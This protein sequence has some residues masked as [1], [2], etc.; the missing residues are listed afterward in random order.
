MGG[1]QGHGASLP[2]HAGDN[3]EMEERLIHMTEKKKMTPEVYEEKR[4][5]LIGLLKECSERLD[6]QAE[7]TK[8]AL[9]GVCEATGERLDA[10]ADDLRRNNF[11]IVLVGEF[12]GGKSTTFDAICDGRD[13]SPRGAG[14][15]TSAC[16]ISAQSVSET[17][18]ECAVLK[19]KSDDDLMRTMYELVRDFVGDNNDDCDEESVRLFPYDPPDRM[20]ELS[21]RRVRELATRAIRREWEIY[22]KVP[23]S[24]GGDEDG[25]LDLLKM[26]TLILK[27]H[28]TPELER[29]RKRERIGI[30]E[31]KPLVVFPQG[32]AERWQKDGENAEWTVTESAFAF[33]GSV[34]CH[35]HSPNLERLGC[36]VTDCPGLFAGPWDTK[37][38]EEAMERAD[39]ILY[40][41]RGNK[42][43]GDEDVRALRK[44]LQ[45]QQG[46]K[47][48]FAINANGRIVD[49]GDE[50]L[51]CVRQNVIENL[52]P[53]DLAVLQRIGVKSVK[54]ADDLDVF[55]A[56]LAFKS[57]EARGEGEEAFNRWRRDVEEALWNYLGLDFYDDEDEKRIQE[58]L[59]DCEELEKESG[60]LAI[61]RKIETEIVGRKFKRVLVD[62]GT[63]QMSYALK[64]VDGKL[65]QLEDAADG[66]I[67]KIKA[68]IEAARLKLKEF[69][70]F[71][72]DGMKKIL[73]EPNDAEF[74]CRDCYDSVFTDNVRS[75]E[76]EVSAAI[77]EAL[78]RNIANI[79]RLGWEKA[80]NSFGKWWNGVCN[81]FRS[82]E[83][84][85]VPDDTQFKAI[86]E[87][88]IRSAMCSVAADGMRGWAVRVS[89]GLDNRFSKT[90]GRSLKRLQEDIARR[91]ET[92]VDDVQPWCGVLA[93]M[94]MDVARIGAIQGASEIVSSG[95][96]ES[97][98]I[99]EVVRGFAFWSAI[100][101]V[102]SVVVYGPVLAIIGALKDLWDGSDD[103]PSIGLR[104]MIKLQAER[105]IT[106][107]LREPLTN[108]FCKRDN[109]EEVLVKI[110]EKVLRHILDRILE[111][112]RDALA[113]QRR[114][115]EE[116]VVRLL[117]AYELALGE[118]RRIAAIAREVRETV[119]APMQH[120]ADAF[121]EE[122]LPYFK[123]DEV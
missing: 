108:A 1:T 29:L 33:L 91:W 49:R 68:A 95:G 63:L 67:D 11:E 113:D 32:W 90:Y 109:R 102:L 75:Y 37:V 22:R 89:Q 48:F 10:I 100:G 73:N 39:A 99:K 55:N 81:F 43:I 69:Q 106:P 28:G 52:R 107:K 92:I 119:I 36:V 121:N 98:E 120:K 57:K 105:L 8:K 101:I 110:D 4:D 77:A 97:H 72:E 112:C 118:R 71:V 79:F 34:E 16:R 115:F 87:P 38:A 7:V 24:Y 51:L 104:Q 21:D 66:N 9:G 26:A 6:D 14:I 2:V 12:Q 88:S 31:L 27:Y 61:R 3:D 76:N 85:F 122:L 93:G 82:E 60:F 53:A 5:R 30:E 45:N 117:A 74:V 25:R 19:W 54:G 114:R 84:E 44:I 78:T 56:L 83:K 86:L 42:T 15:K 18:E 17:E 41:M 64:D 58:L 20:P 62:R 23:G 111:N 80:C 50:G 103:C 70:D 46:D 59:A 40:L 47:L 116:N 123:G 35:I 13:I 94:D 96:A 65:V